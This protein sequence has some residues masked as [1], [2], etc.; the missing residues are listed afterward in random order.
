MDNAE[1]QEL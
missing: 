1:D